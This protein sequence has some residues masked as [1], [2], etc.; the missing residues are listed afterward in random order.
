MTQLYRTPGRAAAGDLNVGYQE[1]LVSVVGGPLL[2][3]A[4]LARGGPGGAGLTLVG[5]VL[6]YRGLTGNCPVYRSIGIS[7]AES[8]GGPLHVEQSLAVNRAPEDVYRFWR[9][10]ANLPQFMKHLESVSPLDD[11]RSHWVAHAP[12]GA[13]VA[14][15]AEMTEDQP[16][17]LIAW[18]SLPGAQVENSGTVRFEPGPSGRGT[19]V[20]VTLDYNPPAGAL[21]AAVAT[22][23]GEAPHQQ[24]AGDL[25][26][27]RSILEAG[28]IPTIS[29]QP[30]GRRTALG[31]LLD[32][33]QHNDAGT[34]QAERLVDEASN[35]SFP[36]SDAPGWVGGHTGEAEREVGGS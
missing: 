10:F 7:T 5:G 1:R 3:L 11:R 13:Q 2:A 27:L 23:F 18:R 14:W 9:E 31:G 6:L 33:A 21:G 19:I 15:D 26:R 8:A 35:E 28:E 20:H 12:A 34:R 30:S 22:L 16:S 4:G 29:G 24:I 32:A 17:R 36:A 25:R